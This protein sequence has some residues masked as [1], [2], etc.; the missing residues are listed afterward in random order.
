M[1]ESTMWHRAA[2]VALTLSVIGGSM[3]CTGG[4]R[5]PAATADATVPLFDGLGTHKRPV[6]TASFEARRYFD[7]GLS[8]LY[9]FNHDEALRAFRRA[10]E[11]DPQFGMAWWGL[12]TANGPHINNSAVAPERERE[13]WEAAQRAAALTAA[14]PDGDRALIE[15]ATK[16]FA[17]RSPKDRKPLDEAYAAAMREAYRSHPTDTDIGALF[18]EAMMDL[19]PWDLWAEDGSPHPGT[20]EIVATL[21]KVIAIDPNHPL[22]LHLYIHAVEASPRPERAVAAADR[23]RNLTPALGHLVHMPSHIDVRTGA[24]DKAMAANTL[25]MEADRLYRERVPRQGFYRIYMAHNHQMYA[26]G[27]IMAGRSAEAIGAIGAMIDG[28]PPDYARDNPSLADG[29]LAMQFE[30]LIRFGRWDDVLAAPD[31][32]P[33]FPLARALRRAAR[34]VARAARGELDEAHAEQQAYR[35]AAAAVP[36]TWPAGNNTAADLLGVVGKLLEG[37]LLF[38]SGK[39]D[40]GLA[41]LREA[42]AREDRLRY[43]EPPDWIQ[44]VRHALGAA[45]LTAGRAAEAEAVYRED[46]RRLPHNGWSLYGLGRSLRLQGK[47]EEAARLEAEFATTWAGAD[48][49]LRSSCF[50]QPGV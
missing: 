8:F 30:V 28:I 10:T 32:E 6:S 2:A 31:P 36:S 33:Q 42:V 15:A 9:A 17:P 3:S 41:A 7:Q 16:R 21:E 47:D 18:A 20:E 24:W 35:T 37:E 11:I 1:G 5:P 45:L 46:L 40:E 34:G 26:W 13:G 12:A 14:L 4:H 48:V 50:C 25:A 22:A 44:P 39:Q 27:A 43:N 23:L 38:R 29:A 19:R 49:S